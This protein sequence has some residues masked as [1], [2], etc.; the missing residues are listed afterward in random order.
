MRPRLGLAVLLGA[1]V[2]AGC[3]PGERPP[4]GIL[5]DSTL[6]EALVGVHLAAARASHTGEPIDSLRAAALA[7]VGTDSVALHRALDAYSRRPEALVALYD[8]VLDRLAQGD[9]TAL[10]SAPSDPLPSDL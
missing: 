2:L 8:R 5:Q 9:E 1:V 7:R 3:R 10:P 6:V 4:R